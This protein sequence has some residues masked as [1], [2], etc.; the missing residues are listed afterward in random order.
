MRGTI[1]DL[2]SGLVKD[3]NRRI[4][5][6]L[7]HYVRTHKTIRLDIELVVEVE[8]RLQENDGSAFCFRTAYDELS[9]RLYSAYSIRQRLPENF[10]PRLPD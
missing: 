1:N 6:L 7:R 8:P 5:A 4:E 10:R 2:I 9:T 3:H